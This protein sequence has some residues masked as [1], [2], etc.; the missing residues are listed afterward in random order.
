MF[1]ESIFSRLARIYPNEINLLNTSYRLNKSL[2]KIPN[3]LFY[4]N[5]LQS[6]TTTQEDYTRYKGNH[7]AEILNSEPHKLILHNVFDA[8]GR[9]PH[10][11]KLVAELVSDSAASSKS[12][13]VIFEPKEQQA[14]LSVQAEAIAAG[15]LV[16]LEP[17]PKKLNT[18]LD[19]L[20]DQ[21]MAEFAVLEEPKN[22]FQGLKIKPIG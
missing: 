1:A 17:T 18:L 13:V 22:G 16:R 7:H 21:G 2:M 10:E 20:K 8:N 11:A 3:T 15:Y 5:L 19:S 4:D 9:S 12:L 14:A 6:A